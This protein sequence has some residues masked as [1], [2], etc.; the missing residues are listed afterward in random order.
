MTT[1]YR[2]HGRTI[3][4]SAVKLEHERVGEVVAEIRDFSETGIF[5]N[6]KDLVDKVD[7]G[8][9][10]RANFNTKMLSN[11]LTVVRMTDEGVGVV[12]K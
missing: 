9:A 6:C 8:D 3:E 5:I 1:S 2:R 12:F 7:V 4:A 11:E 10:I